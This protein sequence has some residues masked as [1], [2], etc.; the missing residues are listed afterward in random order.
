MQAETAEGVRRALNVAIGIPERQALARRRPRTRTRTPIPPRHR[1]H[2]R[3]LAKC[4]DSASRATCSPAPRDSTPALPSR[5][6][7]LSQ[8]H[9]RS[10]HQPPT[11]PPRTPPGPAR[12]RRSRS[13]SGP[14][15]P[16]RTWRWVITTASAVKAYD[17]ALRELAT[18]DRLQPNSGEVAEALGLVLRRRGQMAEAL[19]ELE[20][21]RASTP[22]RRS[23]PRTS[24]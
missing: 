15:W 2:G 11:A 16:K 17:E 3:Q 14:I 9:W 8:A 23:W 19:E 10:T 1:L 22:G 6:R 4:A 21:P 12:R 13:G 20:R 7:A 5:S 18:A 24:A